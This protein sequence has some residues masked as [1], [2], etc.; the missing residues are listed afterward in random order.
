M[1]ECRSLAEWAREQS[2]AEPKATPQ[3]IAKHLGF[4]SATL[5]S[6][7]GDEQSAK[8]KFAVYTKILGDFSNAA[9]AYM[10][11]EACIR[12]EWFPAPKQCLDILNEW[13]PPTGVRTRTLQICDAFWQ[14]EFDRWIARLAGDDASPDDLTGVPANWLSIAEEQGLLRRM[15]DGSFVIRSIWHGPRK[16]AYIAMAAA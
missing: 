7:N 15:D 11:R 16:P 9:L 12:H 13:T 8:M 2:D 10:A 3:E 5:P 1:E 4:L 14:R 6:R